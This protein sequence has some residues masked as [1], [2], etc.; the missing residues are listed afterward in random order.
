MEFLE[1]CVNPKKDEAYYWCGCKLIALDLTTLAER[2]L[3]D[4]PEGYLKT[5]TNVSSDG[6]YILGGRMKD[7]SDTIETDLLHGYVG[8]AEMWEAHPHS[9]IFKTPVEGGETKIVHEENCWIG[10]VNTSPKMPGIVSF[11]HEGPWEKVDNRIWCLNHEIGRA[12]V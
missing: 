3:W 6:K 7:L 2:V 8:F 12:H 11:C 10:H 9:Y 1:T 5:M 4:A